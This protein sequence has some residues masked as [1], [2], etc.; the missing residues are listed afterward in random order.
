MYIIGLTETRQQ[1][2][3]A[4]RQQFL[5][6]LLIVSL[7]TWLDP[8]PAILSYRHNR[9]LDELPSTGTVDDLLAARW[10]VIDCL[11]DTRHD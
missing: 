6:S 11:T 5:G 3:F 1:L 8:F 7:P 10:Q 9:E 4:Q 2:S